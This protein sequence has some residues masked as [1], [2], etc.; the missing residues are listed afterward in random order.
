ML[1]NNLLMLQEALRKKEAELAALQTAYEEK[2]KELSAMEQ[3]LSK[4]YDDK[5]ESS[6]VGGELAKANKK[7]AEA[8][9]QILAH[10]EEIQRLNALVPKQV[11]AHNSIVCSYVTLPMYV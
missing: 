8:N 7:L 6:E 3:S 4:T 2:D 11:N 1:V 9:E 10:K 5:G